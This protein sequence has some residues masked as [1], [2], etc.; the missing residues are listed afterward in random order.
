MPKGISFRTYSENK[1]LL[2]YRIVS[3]VSTTIYI[4]N[5]AG[6]AYPKAS[7]VGK[8]WGMPIEIDELFLKQNYQYLKALFVVNAEPIL[9]LPKRFNLKLN[10]STKAIGDNVS[11]IDTV[12]E[13][14]FDVNINDFNNKI[15]IEASF[16]LTGYFTLAQKGKY[17][18]WML[19]RDGT[20]IKD[21]YGGDIT[22]MGIILTDGV[23]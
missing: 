17:F 22:C 20:D 11:T 16:Q 7:A 13:K 15:L 5:W 1:K 12:D 10:Y 18:N 8:I 4:G 14:Q 6:Y 19:H 9:P 3:G 21:T 2:P 23:I